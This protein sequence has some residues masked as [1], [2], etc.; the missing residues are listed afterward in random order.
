MQIWSTW[1]T[2]DDTDEFLDCFEWWVM[3][4]SP[5][6]SRG[7]K[8]GGNVSTSIKSGIGDLRRDNTF[9]IFLIPA[10]VDIFLGD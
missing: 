2:D 3:M 1:S 8:G 4:G 9:Q 7:G 6:S 5:L 10:C